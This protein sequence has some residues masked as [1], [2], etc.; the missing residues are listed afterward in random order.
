MQAD[1]LELSPS[2]VP[3]VA[4]AREDGVPRDRLVGRCLLLVAIAL[5]FASFGPFGMLQDNDTFWHIVVGRRILDSRSF[6]TVDEFTFTAAGETWF[7]SQWLAECAMAAVDGA[8]A[9]TGLVYVASVILIATYGWG[10]IR[11][12]D[13]GLHWLPTLFLTLLVLAASSYHFHARPHIATIALMAVVVAG[14]SAFE[15]GAIPAARLW[16]LVPLCIVWTNL[17]GGVLG[18]I[19]S[20]GLVAGTWCLGF[21]L[22][23]RSPVQNWRQ[24]G[25]LCAVVTACA[26][27]IFVN[28]YGA[29][30]PRMW[31]RI[32]TS[33]LPHI[34]S[35]HAPLSLREPQGQLVV[36]LAAIY[37][38]LLVR[39]RR[40]PRATSLL[41][42]VWL[43]LAFNRIR[44]GP[45]FAVTFLFVLPRLLI[46][47]RVSDWLQRR[48]W[49]RQPGAGRLSEAVATGSEPSPSPVPLRRRRGVLSA[50][51]LGGVLLLFPLVADVLTWWAIAGVPRAVPKPALWPAKLL[52][53]LQRLRKELGS[54]ARLF[55]EQHFAGFLL[56]ND[57]DSKVFI[58]GRCELFGERFLKRYLQAQSDRKIIRAWERDY[59]FRLALTVPGSPFDRYFASAAGWTVVGRMPH[60]VLYARR[61]A[62]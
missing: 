50:V 54:D 30:I 42:L 46:D 41:P 33:D 56:Y 19:G 53:D 3:S 13:R 34:I 59:R 20:I 24:V 9:F 37:G 31:A 48:G 17:H 55:N 14:L 35:E 22:G 51:I 36:L 12:Y 43:L 23:S 40:F 62:G 18:G 58:D 47:S 52:P 26:L 5:L 10:A 4:G 2:Q 57:A 6:P 15:R 29:G 8:F 38:A 16:W 60:A 49:F 39:S 28:P 45:I 11:L 27:T 44:H 32:M 61:S 1:Q 7:P 21:L 25:Q